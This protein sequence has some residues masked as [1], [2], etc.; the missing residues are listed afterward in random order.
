MFKKK[1]KKKGGLTSVY[2]LGRKAVVIV[3]SHWALT[4]RKKKIIIKSRVMKSREIVDGAAKSQAA[5]GRRERE[6]THI[7]T[8]Q[9]VRT[10]ST[11]RNAKPCKR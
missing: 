7:I 11:S 10:I 8:H 5:E 6:A 4:K 3:Y 2:D 9:N 1:K